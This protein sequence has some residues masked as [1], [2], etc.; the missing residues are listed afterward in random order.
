MNAVM[1]LADLFRSNL[2][3]YSNFMKLFYPKVDLF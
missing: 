2:N 1:R 3:H